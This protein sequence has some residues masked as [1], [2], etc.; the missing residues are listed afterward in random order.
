[1]TE[2]SSNW[3]I[4]E[5]PEVTTASA[6]KTSLLISPNLDAL[7]EHDERTRRQA[8]DVKSPDSFSSSSV[9][10]VF[11]GLPP[12]PRG[13]RKTSI[14]SRNRTSITRQP[15]LRTTSTDSDASDV[16]TPV[17][18]PFINPA[19]TL[20]TILNADDSTISP[21][22]SASLAPDDNY[23]RS[24][25]SPIVTLERDEPSAT[26]LRPP[27]RPKTSESSHSADAPQISLS[28][29]KSKLGIF[30]DAAPNKTMDSPVTPHHAESRSKT[31]KKGKLVKPCEFFF[32]FAVL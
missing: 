8:N 27:S 21:S 23:P 29:L 26:K 15:R 24:P 32:C 31:R 2:V 14:R 17:S 22:I 7:L 28:L 19:P 3:S 5:Q 10:D 18:N 30:A 16:S 1:M 20:D 13:P 11:L 12:P 6:K 9:P 4:G 25:R